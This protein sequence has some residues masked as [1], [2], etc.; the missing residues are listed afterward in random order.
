MT[1]KVK[2]IKQEILSWVLPLAILGLIYIT[3]LHKHMAAG[4]QRVVVAAGIIRP[5]T[6]L[7][8]DDK[9]QID[10]NFRLKSVNGND[11]HFEDLKGKVV[12]M[13]F[14]AT[15]CPPCLAE[16]PDIHDLYESLDTEQV[17]FVMISRD[18]EF[19]RAKK[20]VEN[21]GYTFPIYQQ[22]D[23]LPGVFSMNG[24]PTTFVISKNGKIAL[25]KTGIATYNT[26][27]FK[28]YLRALAD[29]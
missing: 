29:S 10:Y 7:A 9:S 3:G 21:K 1:D 5:E 28:E 11:I 13:N 24:I 15:W 6:N 14:W 23:R 27:E 17:E 20:Y 18:K 8:L 19:G 25:K 22:I 16:M 2:K 4:L 12:F 26:T